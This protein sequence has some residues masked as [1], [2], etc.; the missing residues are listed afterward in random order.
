[1]NTLRKLVAV[2]LLGI[3]A[4]FLSS[5]AKGTVPGLCPNAL[6][7][8][9]CRLAAVGWPFPFVV[10][11]PGISVEGKVD[12]ASGIGGEDRFVA[13]A[14]LECVAFWS[15]VFACLLQGVGRLKKPREK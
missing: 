12:L 7:P 14:W 6:D 11:S 3:V 9:P 1:M 4:T 8:K 15:I 2:V 13:S 5:V 10:D